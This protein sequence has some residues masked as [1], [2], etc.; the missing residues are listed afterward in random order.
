MN[1][2]W[3]ALLSIAALVGA[4]ATRGSRAGHWVVK[5]NG[6]HSWTGVEPGHEVEVLPM[7][8]KGLFLP[9][10]RM[11]GYEGSQFFDAA[12]GTLKE[13]KAEAVYAYKAQFHAEKGWKR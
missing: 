11:P 9:F 13:A 4:V 10:I 2:A 6:D 7:P 8:K 1:E 3:T 5:P 12:E